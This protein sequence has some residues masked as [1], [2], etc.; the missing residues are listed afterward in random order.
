M[1]RLNANHKARLTATFRHLDEL[2]SQALRNLDEVEARSPFSEHI[3]DTTPVQRKV[4]ADYVG[5]VRATMLTILERL[6]MPRPQPHVSSIWAAR[7]ALVSAEIAVEELKPRYMRG[8]GELSPTASAD[9]DR[10]VAELLELLR[11]TSSYLAQS[12][13]RDIH[14]RLKKIE[15]TSLDI[16]VLRELDRV[17]TAHGLV[18]FRGALDMV[19]ERLEW[20]GFE[21]ALFGRVNSGKSSLLNHLLQID[22]LPVGVTP[23]TAIPTRVT[24][25]DKARTRVW[26]A[27][28]LPLDTDLDALHEFV[29]EEHNPSNVKHVTRVQ[30]E[31][32][33]PRLHGGIAF[34]DTPGLGSLAFPGAAEALAYLP[35][36]DLGIVLLD[37]ASSL[38]PE[39]VSLV[40]TIHR[41][42][43][44]V[45]V[46]VSKADLLAPDDHRR[47][48]DYVAEQLRAETGLGVP[49]NLVSV[50]RMYSSLCDSWFEEAL[51]PC[52]Q[53]HKKLAEGSVHRKI[54]ALRDAVVVAL[55]QSLRSRPESM[56]SR[57][58][59]KARTVEEILSIALAELDHAH[60][61]RPDI[62]IQLCQEV[63]DILDKAAYHAALRWHQSRDASWDITPLLSS[64][65][66]QRT[67][68]A[69]TTI[70]QGLMAIRASLASALGMTVETAGITQTDDEELA[71]PTSMP[72][73]DD[74]DLTQPIV[75]HW[76]VLGFLG[77]NALYRNIRKQ[78]EHLTKLEITDV[79]L[80]YAKRL[81]EW[82]S[83]MLTELRRQ[84]TVRSD[85]VRATIGRPDEPAGGHSV[86]DIS[87][88]ENDL[89]KLEQLSA[90]TVRSEA[91]APATTA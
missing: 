14:A 5:H 38:A 23:V 78:L 91:L 35:R 56:A 40:D 47:T 79:L 49:V 58:A 69:A 61:E 12:T 86:V 1:A 67:K 77:Q 19:V 21:V 13:G 82:R 64:A 48:L 27:E 89:A 76:P 28:A 75:L 2:L 26:F 57:V 30:V 88:I 33:A 18:E 17:I 81:E 71:Q 43:A 51:R 46:L 66:S 15:H 72:L 53:D 25:G 11:R 41:S 87:A 60:Q 31:L 8:Y 73:F 32:P 90:P 29:T 22:V 59:S 63:D 42:G 39:D 84:Y 9:L 80:R 24:Y 65:I 36:C 3:L 45:M 44:S 55:Q 4:A 50:R 68:K 6:Q 83:Q 10:V 54:D 85:L 52:L 62:I 34:V 16:A 20:Q 70:V 37:A 7:T 74:S